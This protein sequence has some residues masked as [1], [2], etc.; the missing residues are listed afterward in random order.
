MAKKYDSFCVESRKSGV[1]EEAGK[2][3]YPLH[4]VLSEDKSSATKYGKD[5]FSTGKR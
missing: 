5:G 2:R 1:K 4:K 3:A